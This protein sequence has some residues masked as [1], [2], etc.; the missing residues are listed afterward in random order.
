MKPILSPS[1]MCAD[2][3]CLTEEI[4]ALDKAGA[5]GFHLD[6]MDGEFVPNFA[7]SWL[8][9]AVVRKATTKPLDVHLMVKNPLVYLPYALKDAIDCV[10]V[11]YESNNTEACLNAIKK[12]GLKVGLVIN[13]NTMLD[14]IIIYEHLINKLLVM[15][16]HPGFYGSPAVPE[17]ELKIQQLVDIKNRRFSIALDGAVS[18]ELIKYWH[19][20]GVEEFVLGTA[21]GLFGLNRKGR[22]YEDIISAIVLN[23]S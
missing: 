17:V 5:D 20:R 18:Q 1:I 3:G 19:P 9:V 6:I 11:H 13:P 12:A 14:E 21:S 22:S 23:N 15:R 10:Y 16:V 2:L 4:Q 7:L 8:D